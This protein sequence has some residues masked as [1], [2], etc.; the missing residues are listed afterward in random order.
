MNKWLTVI[1]FVFSS[2]INAESLA[3]DDADVDVFDKASVQRGA[4]LFVDYCIGC[5]SAQHL[6]YS[7]LA[8]DMDISEEDIKK[9]YLSATAK[10]GDG[11][12]SAMD[13]EHAEKWFGTPTP[14]LSVTARVRGAD[15]LYTYLRGFYTDESR[16][17]GVNNIV[18]K[19]VAMPNVFWKLQGIQNRVIR[20]T[21]GDDEPIE[22]GL[23]QAGIMT[24]DEFDSAMRD[25]VNFMVYLGEPAM[26]ERIPLGK[27]VIL[28]LLV[29]LVPAY[30]LKKEYWKDVH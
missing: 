16:P 11:M 29:F 28:F 10:I 9:S 2:G 15:W 17:F 23:A 13:A 12:I 20:K 8:E 6:R 1:V 14:D 3:L 30:L 21:D 5:H 24:P 22:I 19:D 27:Y 7:R 26:L 18:F 4:Q 25:L